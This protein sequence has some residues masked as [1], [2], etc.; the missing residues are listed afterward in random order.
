MEYRTLGRTGLRTSILGTGGFHYLEI[1]AAETQALLNHYLDAGGNYVETAP[2][3]GNGES[4]L[5]VGPVVARRRN[6][7]VLTTKC[8][9][10]DR[11]TAAR[12]IDLSL[13][14]LQTDHV[15]ILLMHHVQL[16]ADLDTIFS[17][18][19][20]MR[21][22]ED[23]RAAGKV[24][25]IGMS[26]HGHPE[27]MIQ[28]LERYPL[29]VIMTGMNYYDRF[30]FPR[31]EEKLLPM[32]VERGVGIV[33]MKGLADGYLWR[34]AQNA[35]RY[36]WSLPIGTLALGWNT[37][38]MLEQDLAWAEAFTP[39]TDEERERLFTEAP[40][41]GTYVCRLCDK[42]LPCPEG[43]D[44]PRLFELEG[45]YDRQMWDGVVRDPADFALRNR[46]RFWFE[47]NNERARAAYAKA[48]VKA[49]ACTNCGDCEPRC[50]YGLPIVRKLRHT[51][52]KLSGLPVLY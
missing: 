9:P 43:I 11:E 41:L 47:Y 1:S 39:L 35:L 36:A 19:G 44:I 34:S 26:N 33:G 3:Y 25:F 46:L 13:K 50:P 20:A 29:D 15:D 52:A 31:I 16:Q 45:V 28:A 7:M 14:Q 40:E 27:L 48:A 8:H 12:T 23:A 10:R 4:E 5:K 17:D 42:C 24:R 6:E 37:P 32:A 18:D 38:E 22:A 2:Q 51:N 30:N 21:A 49:D